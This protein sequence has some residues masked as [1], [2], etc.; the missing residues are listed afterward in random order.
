MTEILPVVDGND[1]VVG[2]KERALVHRDGDLH[3]VSHVWVYNSKGEILC[4]KR[5]GKVEVRPGVWDY[6]V[7]GHVKFGS[8]Y[9]E[10][11]LAELDEELGI[12]ANKGSLKH[13]FNTRAD[14]FDGEIKCVMFVDTFALQCEG[15]ASELKLD[16]SVSQ[17]KWFSLEELESIRKGVDKR[18]EFFGFLTFE[19]GSQKIRELLQ[20]H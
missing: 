4:Q 13:L 14:I 20:K 2:K 19:Q 8:T 10:T 1:E 16:E 12:N 17:A 15:D 18:F 9:E 11:A 6:P 3:R 5:S 7:G